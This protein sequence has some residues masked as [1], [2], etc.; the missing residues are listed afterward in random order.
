MQHFPHPHTYNSHT[1]TNKQRAGGGIEQGDQY[2][3]NSRSSHLHTHIHSKKKK[4]RERAGVSNRE[5][6]MQQDLMDG[7]GADGAFSDAF[8][9][10]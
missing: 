8:D 9:Q 7:I 2:A 6:S 3:T 10:V 4:N 5:I 1:K